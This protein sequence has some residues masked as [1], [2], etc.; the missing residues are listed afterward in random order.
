MNKSRTSQR[1]QRPLAMTL[2]CGAML[3]TL[4]GCVEMMVGSAVVGT[5]AAS[6]RR[7]FGAQTEDQA[8]VV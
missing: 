5:V 8:I 2:L 3:A 1:W 6:D 4:S 7:T